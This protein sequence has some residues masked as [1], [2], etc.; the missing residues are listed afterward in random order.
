M[1][2]SSILSK[3]VRLAKQVAKCLPYPL[4]IP[5]ILS[6]SIVV[7]VVH[8]EHTLPSCIETCGEAPLLPE[9]EVEGGTLL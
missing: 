9:L 4:F 1:E 5:F 7:G 2:N 3:T 6:S 8:A